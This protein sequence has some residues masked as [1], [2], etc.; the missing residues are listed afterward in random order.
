MVPED[1]KKVMTFITT[2]LETHKTVQI[3]NALKQTIDRELKADEWEDLIIRIE[4]N[5]KYK[6]SLSQSSLGYFVHKSK[7]KPFQEKYWWL[8][9]I[10]TLILGFWIDIGKEAMK[11]ELWPETSQLKQTPPASN[12]TLANNKI[13]QKLNI[14]KDVK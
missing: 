5:D 4:E 3:A 9:A 8:I 11:R 14:S 2:T 6:V 13:H 10:I 12:D 7:P 1:I